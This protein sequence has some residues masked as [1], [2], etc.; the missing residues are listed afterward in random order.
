LDPSFPD[1]NKGNDIDLF[2]YGLNENDAREKLRHIFNTV[3]K[4]TNGK[5]DII[6]TKNAIT[7]IGSFPYHHI[8]II[9]R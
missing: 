2:I 9:M 1:I 8:Q 3:Q 6:R 5:G 4:N 7:I